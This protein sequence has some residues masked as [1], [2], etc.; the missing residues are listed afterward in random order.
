MIKREITYDDFY[1]G[2]IQELTEIVYFNHTLMT[3][4]RY[5]EEYGSYFYDD[6]NRISK[7]IDFDK[8]SSGEI[9]SN[10]GLDL[11]TNPIVNKFVQR[12]LPC[13][14]AEVQDGLLVQNQ[15][16]FDNFNSAPYFMEFMNFNFFTEIMNLVFKN[17]G[18][19]PDK[20]GKTAKK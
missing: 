5:E 8:L 10:E 7:V 3:L 20:K 12:V 9:S 2:E 17:Q 14:Y 1:N 15:E 16:T 13:M 19:A 4:K 18:K 11:M 6:F